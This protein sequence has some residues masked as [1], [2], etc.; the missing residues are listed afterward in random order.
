[1]ILSEKILTLRKKNGWSQ[2]ELAEKLNVTR[3]SV[4]KW[5]IAASI[6]DIG[7][8]LELAQIFDVT[9]D[10]LL[11]DDMEEMQYAPDSEIHETS[12]GPRV[13]VQEANEYFT[14]KKRSGKSM[15]L[16]AALFI[17]CPSPLLALMGFSELPSFPLSDELSAGLG[18]ILLLLLVS[19]G[20]AVS[21][22]DESRMKRF[23]YLKN[24]DFE[25]EYG[26]AG[27]AEE[28]RESFRETYTRMQEIGISLCV[29]SAV[30]ILIAGFV[31]APDAAG[32]FTVILLLIFIAT[33]VFIFSVSGCIQD[34]YDLLLEEG[35][36][37]PK[38]RAKDRRIKIFS[39][40]YW[41]IIT[42]V[43]LVWTLRE[44]Q[45]R[46]TWIVWVVGGLLYAAIAAVLKKE[47]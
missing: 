27:I 22:F 40:F 23:H 43:Y 37:S 24:F 44:R 25:L 7:K 46:T 47:D 31:D 32:S 2:E 15:G 34:S 3:Q 16:A 26:V 20:I 30:P 42:A 38:E 36:F 21:V 1:M 8:I 39:R 9:T 10:F 17:L 41:P 11:K 18:V 12:R 19:A 28:K 5:E 45:W 13:S 33:A 35:K 4:S 29:M 6:P 14:C